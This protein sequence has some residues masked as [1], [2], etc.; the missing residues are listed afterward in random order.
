LSQEPFVCFIQE[1]SWEQGIVNVNIPVKNKV[2]EDVAEERSFGILLS[3]AEK[4]GKIWE[5]HL[6]NVDYWRL[7]DVCHQDISTLD[8]N[9]WLNNTII[10]VYT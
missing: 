9:Q 5:T 8:P 2:S 3:D 1:C 6:N 10:D 4:N 7:G